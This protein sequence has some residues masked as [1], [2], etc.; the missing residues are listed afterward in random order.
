MFLRNVQG[1]LVLFIKQK[2]NFREF[3]TR[4]IKNVLQKKNLNRY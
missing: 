2:N 4:G 3:Q 1:I